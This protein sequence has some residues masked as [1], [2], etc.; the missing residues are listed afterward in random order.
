MCP[1]PLGVV[2]PAL[3]NLPAVLG[4]IH[5]APPGTFT[6]TGRAL[7]AIVDMLP[8][9]QSSDPDVVPES[10]IIVLATDGNPNDC[11]APETNFQPSIDA[12]MKAAAKHQKLFVISVGNDSSAMHL[13]QMANIGAGLA[14]ECRPWGE[15]LLS[16]EQR[17]A[18][19]HALRSHRG[20]ARLRSHPRG[21]RC[22]AG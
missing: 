10:P 16:R 4:G 11:M 21:Q 3:D 22:D 9:G 1:L 14:I 5:D 17:R 6:P 8:D 15:G 19:H 13:Q 2:A 20:A 7:D 12:A 18:G